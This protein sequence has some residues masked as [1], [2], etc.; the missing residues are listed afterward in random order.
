M[1]RR[2]GEDF[3]VLTAE[4]V[5]ELGLLG[6]GEPTVETTNRMGNILLLSA[7]E[8]IYDFREIL[9]DERFPMI[10]HH[11]GLTPEEMRIPLVIA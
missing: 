5:Q 9:G 4:E 1:G 10:S 3:I 7:G 2:F 6:V 8:A 11:G